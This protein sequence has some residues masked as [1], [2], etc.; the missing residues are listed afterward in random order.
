M[1]KKNLLHKSLAIVIATI[2]LVFVASCH[3]GNKSGNQAQTGVDSSSMKEISSNVKDVVY[4]LPTPF[5]M[6]RMLNTMGASYISSILNPVDKAEKYFTEKSKAVN[7]GVY[8]ADL[9]YAA[10]Y[11]QKQDVKLYSRALKVLIDELGISVDYSNML[12]DEFKDKINNK[13]TLIKIITNTYYDTYKDLSSKGNQ[14]LSVMMASGM[15]IELMYIATNISKD[16]YNN[17]DIVKLVANQKDSYQKLLDLLSKHDK[18]ADI[19]DVENKLLILKPVY[20]KV[21][22]GLYEKDYLLILKTVQDIR[23]SFVS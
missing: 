18:S 17:S 7:L 21:E 15:W 13:D 3:N 16:T 14:D 19:K 1:L 8:G 9:S 23:K 10:T 20:D 4:P 11:D 22:K 12:S 2:V 6:T 5:E